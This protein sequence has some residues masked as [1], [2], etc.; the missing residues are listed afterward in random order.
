MPVACLG[1][2]G[3]VTEG[4]ARPTN[5]AWEIREESLSLVLGGASTRL[6]NDLAGT[7][8]GML[9]LAPS[10]VMELNKG[11]QARRPSNVAVIAAGTGLGE[12]GLVTAGA[13]WSTVPTEG[14]H[15]DFAP[16][17]A[18]Q[19]ALLQFL[20]REFSHVSYERALSG[21]GLHNIYRFLLE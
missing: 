18:E 17:G 5:I 16:R 6:V 2:P 12:A 4:I 10:D 11:Q 1:V 20:E 21:P 3:P 13:G 9:Y 7:A 14:G 8:Y 19:I 15:C